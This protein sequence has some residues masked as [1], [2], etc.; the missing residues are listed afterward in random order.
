MAPQYQFRPMSVQD[1]PLVH[2]W[3]GAPHVAQWWRDPD[4]Q[5]ALVSGDLDDPAVDQFI[6]T[7]PKRGPRAGSASTPPAPAALIS[8]SASPT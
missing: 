7:I 1:L 5:F 4:V 8:S 2:R 3:L 6:A